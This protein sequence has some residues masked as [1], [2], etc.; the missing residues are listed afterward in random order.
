MIPNAHPMKG[1]RGKLRINAR[2]SKQIVW[3]GSAARPMRQRGA[4]P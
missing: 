3:R 4:A 1:L 2:R